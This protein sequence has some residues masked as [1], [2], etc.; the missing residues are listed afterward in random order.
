MKRIFDVAAAAAGLVLLCPVLIVIAAAIKLGSP[1]PVFYRGVRAGLGGRR[2]RIYKFRTMVV[3]AEKLGGPTTSDTDPRLTSV[4]ERL[5]KYKLDELPQL[6][7]VFVGDMSLVGP[8]PQVTDIVADYDT[9]E[10]RL[11]EVRPG[12]TDYASLK[13]RDEGG[14]LEGYDDPHEAYMRIIHPEK[15]R[16]GLEYV[17]NHNLL[18]DIRIILRTV[19]AIIFK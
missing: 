17:D 4:G 14:M 10:R 1:G 9:E 13:F 11:L 15:I 16:L 19:H 6:I 5:R 2:F 3:D 12:I 7:N 18:E 8:R